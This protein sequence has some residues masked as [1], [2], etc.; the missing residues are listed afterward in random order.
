MSFPPILSVPDEPTA[1]LLRLVALY[2]G[3][4]QVPEILV[5]KVAE[6]EFL[7]P[8]GAKAFGT[9]TAARLVASLTPAAAQLLGATPEDQ[10][11]VIPMSSTIY[12]RLC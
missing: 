12:I 11:K 4:T 10:A 3:L 2:G 6:A 8:D 9:V 5:G 1:N 7:A